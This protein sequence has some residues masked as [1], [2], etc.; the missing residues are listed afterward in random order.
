MSQATGIPE[1]RLQFLGYAPQKGMTRDPSGAMVFQGVD[2]K[3]NSMQYTF[4]ISGEGKNKT[5][6]VE[7]RTSNEEKFRSN[8]ALDPWKSGTARSP[9][10]RADAEGQR[11]VTLATIKSGWEP[12]P[13][14]LPP[15][16]RREDWNGNRAASL[17]RLE[18]LARSKNKADFPTIRG[19]EYV[20]IRIGETQYSWDDPKT[21]NE[22]GLRAKEMYLL[23][24][25]GTGGR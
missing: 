22:A 2:S 15:N 16:T 4:G 19:G 12:N 8:F 11:A 5:V 10:P 1:N 17:V 7:T 21:F 25:Y 20:K 24:T 14:K 23:Q 13:A 6:H 18:R 3:G 9:S